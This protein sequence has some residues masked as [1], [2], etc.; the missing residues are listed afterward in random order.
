MTPE[1]SGTRSTSND[2]RW[3]VGCGLIFLLVCSA[4]WWMVQLSSDSKSGNSSGNASN[5]CAAAFSNAA[6]VS[7]LEDTVSDIDPAVRGCGSV[8]EWNSNARNY[9]EVVPSDVDPEQYLANRCKYGVGL[10]TTSLCIEI[11]QTRPEL[12]P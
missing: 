4:P 1:S 2:T 7:S 3:Y 10:S 12:F 11:Q 6:A 5:S 9:P 8:A